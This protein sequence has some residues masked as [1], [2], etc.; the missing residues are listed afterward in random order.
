VS[1]QEV[2][3][4][5]LLDIVVGDGFASAHDGHGLRTRRRSAADQGEPCGEAKDERREAM[6]ERGRHDHIRY[7]NRLELERGGRKS[8][9]R[10]RSGHRFY[11][12]TPPPAE[13]AVVARGRKPICS[14]KAGTSN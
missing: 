2:Q 5:A 1:G 6:R 10:L 13:A 14:M 4:A 8:V 11:W 7:I 9:L 12:I 3:L